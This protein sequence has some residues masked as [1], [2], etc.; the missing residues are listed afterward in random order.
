MTRCLQCL[1]ML[2]LALPAPRALAAKCDRSCTLRCMQQVV[3][4]RAH[5]Y[6]EIASEAAHTYGVPLELMM[7]MM[8]TESN[9]Y[10][11]AVSSKGALG[12]M[13][14][15]PTT[16]EYLGLRDIRDPRENIFGAA[17]LIRILANQT[18]L[19]MVL[20]I[21]GYHAGLGA[22]RKYNGVP[23]YKSTR[24]YVRAVTKRYF[25]FREHVKLCSGVV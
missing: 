22:V 12:L 16:G 3:P 17:K 21:A 9:Y 20:V 4:A 24:K 10:P 19:D 14:I 5:T 6:L 13:Q 18:D 1:L 23:R 7:A 2:A 11:T 25:A 8:R 15:M